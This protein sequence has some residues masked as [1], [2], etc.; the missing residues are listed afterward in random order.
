M[1]SEPVPHRLRVMLVDDH[2]VV[3]SGIKSLLHATDDIS[4][5]AEAASLFRYPQV[6]RI[7]E[8]DELG[9]FMIEPDI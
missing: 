2:E 4:V 6:T 3:R 5:V 7:H 1:T 8:A 9:R